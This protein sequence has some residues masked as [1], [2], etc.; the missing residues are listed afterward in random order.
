MA[1][2]H[3]Y[4]NQGIIFQVSLLC[5]FV[6]GVIFPGGNCSRILSEGEGAWVNVRGVFVKVVIDF[7]FYYFQVPRRRMFLETSARCRSIP[8]ASLYS[9]CAPGC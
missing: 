6:P 5:G 2:I 4:T 1:L 3:A 9:T 7:F 8:H